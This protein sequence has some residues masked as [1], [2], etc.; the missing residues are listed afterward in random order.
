MRSRPAVAAFVACLAIASA[1]RAGEPMNREVAWSPSWPKFRP[2]EYVGT[3]AL[4]AALAVYATVRGPPETPRWRGGILF[5]DDVE[6]A[7]A[8]GPQ[9]RQ[10]ARVVSDVLWYGGGALPF[11]VDLPV[12]WLA[13]RKPDVAGQMLLMNLEAFAIAGALNRVLQFETGRARPAADGCADDPGYDDLCGSRSLNA[14]F[15]SGHTLGV[16]TAAGLTCVHHEHLPLYGDPLADRGVCAAMI[17]ATVATASTR[18]IGDRHHAS[19]VIVGGALGFAVGYGLPKLL[20]Y[21]ND[22]S[23][24]GSRSQAVV[25]LGGPDGVR[26]AWVGSF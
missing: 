20:H 1:A 11:L 23:S 12:A 25:P 4:G 15:P 16:A 7:L 24:A 26:F 22:A 6:R 9:G 17:L 5:D 19:D 18:V 3:F 2:V 8:A 13:H 21:R 10:R 14:S